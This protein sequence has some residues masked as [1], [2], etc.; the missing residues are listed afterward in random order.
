MTTP[1]SVE[2][3]KDMFVD[4]LSHFFK[5]LAD[6]DLDR[7]SIPILRDFLRKQVLLQFTIQ[8]GLHESTDIVLIQSSGLGFVFSHVFG[9]LDN[10]HAG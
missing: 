1:G 4:I 5:V 9:Q 6:Q 7:L 2:F 8:V 10:S 3:D